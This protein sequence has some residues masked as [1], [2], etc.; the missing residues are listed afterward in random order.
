MKKIIF[1]VVMLIATSPALVLYAQNDY[2]I[3]DTEPMVKK[4]MQ[5]DPGYALR[6]AQLE[7]FTKDYVDN[8]DP[9]AQKSS[10][11]GVYVIPVVFHIIHN[12]GNENIPKSQV[13]SAVNHFNKSFRNLWADTVNVNPAFKSIIADCDIEFKLAQLDPNGNCTDGITRTVSSLTYDASDNVKSLINWP[14]NKYFNIWVVQNIASGAAGFAYYPG[15]SFSND[16]VV[17]RYDY[18]GTGSNYNIRSLTHEAGHW[19][20]L[21]HT[22]GST[23]SSG[24]P[25]NCS[26][27]DFVQDTPNTVGVANFSCSYSQVTCNSLDNVE[28]YMD[29]A[30]CSYMFTIG[31]KNRMHAALNS[32][33]GGRNNLHNMA[34]LIAT[35]TDP[36]Y[37]AVACEPIADFKKDIKYVCTGSSVSFQDLSWR[38]DPTSWQWDFPGGSPSSSTSQNPTIT[39]NTP[40]LYDV[41]LTASNAGGTN[42]FSVTGMIVVSPATSPIG[43]PVSEDFENVTIPDSYKWLIEN[44]IGNEWHLSSVASTSGSQSMRLIN[45]SGNP[46]G[47]KDAFVTPGYDFTN[48]INGALTFQL[49]FA[50]RSTSSTDQLRVYSSSDCGANWSTR[51]AKIGINLT[52]NGISA[53]SFIP[54]A[55]NQ[56]DLQTVSVGSTSISNKPNVRFKFEFSMDSGNNIYIDDINITGTSTVGIDDVEF[57]ATLNVYPN[58][59]DGPTTTSFSLSEANQ[60]KIDI[61]DITGRVVEQVADQAMVPGKYNFEIG[62]N[63]PAGSYFVRYSVG[64]NNMT[65]KLV[66][67]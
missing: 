25:Q 18:T 6:R 41:T 58:P 39:Y 10:G 14:S 48:I 20:N 44:E 21:A 40:G 55:A 43:I 63:L 16:G 31:Q 17:M 42:S 8:I 19:L 50:I 11:T 35:G 37:S 59:T 57:L 24:L 13:L 51:Y 7:A 47:S 52:T 65:R 22:W 28:N 23:N 36:N 60:V 56:W 2:R 46:T 53:A 33:A 1:C 61:V 5:A 3:C 32:G 30:G 54:S 4:A 26:N 66:K 64:D 45:H 67:M 15:A 9:S 38:G 49:A 62:S 12:Y 34:N 27:D 29:Y